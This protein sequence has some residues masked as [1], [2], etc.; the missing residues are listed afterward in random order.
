MP[1]PHARA[2]VWMRRALRVEDNYALLAALHDAD[3]VLPVLCLSSDPRYRTDSPR[4]RFVRGCIVALDQELRKRGSRLFVLTGDIERE[5]PR[6][7]RRA[8]VSVVYAVR[9]YDPH[10]QE[11]DRRIATA[12]HDAGAEFKTVKDAVLMEGKEILNQAGQPFKV[13]S[14]YQRAWFLNSTSISPVMPKLRRLSTPQH[15]EGSRALGEVWNLAYEP[16]DGGE[17]AAH[18][19]LLRFLR[20]SLRHYKERRDIPALDGTSRLSPF[21][22]VGAISIRKVYHAASELRTH[23]SPS[24]RQ[25]INAFISELIW[26][27]FYYQILANIPS[28]VKQAFREELRNVSWSENRHHFDAWCKGET[29]YPIVDAGMRQLAQEGWMHNRVRMIVASFLTKDLHINWQWGERFFFEHLC[30]ADIASNN[31]GW[32]WCAGTGTDAAPWFRIFNPLRQ[33][34]RFDPNGVYIKRY[35]PELRGVP[36]Q[37]IHAPHTMPPALQRELGCVIGR[38]YPQPI[39]EHAEATKRFKEMYTGARSRAR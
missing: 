37:F 32:Q 5:L 4:R 34:K 12:L 21:L 9:T 38:H 35:V 6:F 28:V 14:A 1:K 20:L 23:A 22:S 29:G 8:G 36:A 7:A 2:I 39:V 26:R 17:L 33:S 15:V 18:K 13:F 27:E 16:H 25:N 11:R 31:G 30:D 19:Q 10:S 24:E 3:E